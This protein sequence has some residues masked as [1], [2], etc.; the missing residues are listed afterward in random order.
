MYVVAGRGLLL[1]DIYTPTG[2]TKLNP[3]GSRWWSL[4]LKFKGKVMKNSEKA[5]KIG[6]YNK[7]YTNCDG[8]SA[9][10]DVYDILEGSNVTCP[11]LQHL[12][13]KSLNIGARGY[14]DV[15]TDLD[16]IIASAIRAKELEIQRQRLR[17]A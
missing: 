9:I 12:T 4:L 16:D 13:K 8:D 2:S 14:K 10:L 11:A 15:L 5:K 1:C 7:L 6:K 3:I 17:E